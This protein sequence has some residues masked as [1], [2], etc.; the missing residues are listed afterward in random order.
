MGR[1]ERRAAR[2]GRVGRG[3]IPCLVLSG[4]LAVSSGPIGAAE[5]P[6]VILLMADDLG[7]GDTGYNGST[8]VQTPHLDRMAGEGLRFD[9]F[10]A[11]APVCSPTRASVLTGRHPF[12]TGVFSANVGRLRPEE[13]T[14]A[15]ILQA[16]GY[17]TGLFGKWHLGTFTDTLTD[18]NRGR[19]GASVLVN[20]PSRHGFDVYFATEA[21]VPTF[22]PMR[23]PSRQ[24]PAFGW[25][26][27]GPEE[28][29]T[30]YGTRYWTAAGEVTEG[31]EGDDSGVIMDRALPFIEA[32]VR[33]G[34][35]FLAVVW[36]HT[37]HFPVV[38]GPDHGAL[39]A[40]RGFKPRN[41]AGAITA[42][43]EQVGRLR[44]RLRDLGVARDTMVWF[45]SDNGPERNAPG[46]TG[47]FRERKRSLYEG[48][49]RVPGLLAWPAVVEGPRVTAVPA[50]T[51]DY[52]PTILDALGLAPP[53]DR[54]L[55]GVSL[56]PVLQGR[57]FTR[58]GPFGFASG[59][60]VAFVDGAHKIYRREPGAP[61]ELYDLVEDPYEE[62]D[63][64]SAHQDKAARLLLDFRSWLRSVRRSF[65]GG[66]YGGGFEDPLDQSWPILEEPRTSR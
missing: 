19:P 54:P 55:D 40:G 45:T 41:F 21:K 37:P 66:D 39:Y 63:L 28:E 47:G 33:S 38:A 35:P 13:T 23:R 64:A 22:D 11:A 8:L 53:T 32:S 25:D 20:P 16:A 56:L 60:Q 61:L 58:S 48:G 59:G 49:V 26:P 46:E 34:S 24:V 2:P 51:S 6:N 3:S 12:R 5:R 44:A 62:T 57:S 29:W 31:L 1:E 36:F 10:Y 14:L 4:A 42:L 52:L 15:E 43:D 7:W 18:S 30:S 27:L 9:R 50:V 65:E 17:R